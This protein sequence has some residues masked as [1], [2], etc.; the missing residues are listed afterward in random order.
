MSLVW[1]IALFGPIELI[2][3]HEAAIVLRMSLVAQGGTP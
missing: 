1:L 2:I 3:E